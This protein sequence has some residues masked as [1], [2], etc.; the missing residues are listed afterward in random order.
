[1]V[2]DRSRPEEELEH[3]PEDGVGE[4]SRAPD[5]VS[6]RRAGAVPDDA[7]RAKDTH[8]DCRRPGGADCAAALAQGAEDKANFVGPQEIVGPAA[9]QANGL[10]KIGAR[11]VPASAVGVVDDVDAR[12]CVFFRRVIARDDAMRNVSPVSQ[13]KPHAA[14][15]RNSNY[16]RA[17]AI[18]SFA[19]I[20]IDVG[21][22][23]EEELYCSDVNHR[24]VNRLKDGRFG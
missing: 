19:T 24:S 20:Q 14:W 4:A 11:G 2:V 3:D 23:R 9:R 8:E 21:P 10:Q 1:M 17:H 12:A 7:R 18:K 22:V 5:V 6:P 16:E 13:E 15:L